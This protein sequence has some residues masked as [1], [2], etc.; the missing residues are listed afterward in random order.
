[1]EKQERRLIPP[2]TVVREELSRNYEQARLLRRLLKLSEDSA[3]EDYRRNSEQHHR[4]PGAPE[5]E[6]VTP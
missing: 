2:P 5:P 6:G 3:V 4:Q 1:M